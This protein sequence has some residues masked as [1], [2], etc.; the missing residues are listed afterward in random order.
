MS[1]YGSTKDILLQEK[2]QTRIIYY[3]HV[4]VYIE[5]YYHILIDY[6]DLIDRYR[7]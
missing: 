7:L 2:K 3:R 4:Y 1:T 5:S 6:I